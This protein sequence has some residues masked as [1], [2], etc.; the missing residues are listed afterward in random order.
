MLKKPII[1][2]DVDGVLHPFHGHIPAS[3]V[4]TFHRTCMH[5]LQR[6]V[7]EFD[8]EIVLSS[9]WRNF[10]STRNRLLAN[11]A[12]YGMTYSRWIEPDSASSSASVSANKLRKIIAFVQAHNPPEWLVLDDEDLVNLSGADR[13]SLMVQL[14]SSRFVQ[15][16]PQTGLVPSDT[17]KALSILSSDD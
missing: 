6:I 14:F 11:L 3:E 1:F 17:V 7:E 16:D 15:T 5:E 8:A 2:L 12:E 9:S 4:T 13:D 10:A